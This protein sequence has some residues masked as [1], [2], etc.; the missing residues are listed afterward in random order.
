M[1]RKVDLKAALAAVADH[2]ATEMTLAE[3]ILAWTA[4]HP[5]GST[6][7]LS[8]WQDAFATTSAWDLT[9]EQLTACAHALIQGGY[10]PG[11]V[12]RDLSSLGSA[13][14]WA[15]RHR[16]NPRGFRSPTLG[17]ERYEEPIRRVELDSNQVQRLL[18]R[19][20]AFR[21]RRFAAFVHLL[22]DTGARKSELLE[23]TWSQVDLQ[24][25]T[26]I[27]PTTKTDRPRILHFRPETGE[28]MRRIWKSTP[29]EQ[30]LFAAKAPG[31]HLIYRTQWA[32]LT[33]DVGLP[34]LH[35]HDLRHVAAASLLRA[36]VTLAVAS[37]VLGHSSLVLQRR[38]GHLETGALRAAQEQRWQAA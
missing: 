16:L 34:D 3:L 36:G 22:V 10:A 27:C 6:S 23:R 37:Q 32:C 17:V 26:I 15:Q 1:N 25:G 35:M 13:Y 31:M 38:Y 30:L 2:Q 24:A 11:S 19:S 29:S 9:T 18:N 28:L 8:K 33:K 5:D 14:R 21:D 12:N 7:R 4:A 20:F